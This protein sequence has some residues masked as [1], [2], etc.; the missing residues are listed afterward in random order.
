MPAA[1]TLLCRASKSP[2]HVLDLTILGKVLVPGPCNHTASCRLLLCMGVLL[3]A[4]H[5]GRCNQRSG[6]FQSEA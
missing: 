1:A 3:A 2:I 5:H 6:R 4:W